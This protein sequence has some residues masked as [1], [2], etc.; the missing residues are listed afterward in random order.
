[1]VATDNHS[2][3][4]LD[5]ADQT[6][7][8]LYDF[9]PSPPTHTAISLPA[10]VVGVRL[11]RV[12]ST[13]ADTVWV[14]VIDSNTPPNHPQSAYYLHYNGSDWTTNGVQPGWLA[15]GQSLKVNR[16]STVQEAVNVGSSQVT[17]V[18]IF[19]A[20]DDG[21]YYATTNTPTAGSDWKSANDQSGLQGVAI[22]NV[23]CGR[24][25]F[26]LGVETSRIFAATDTSLYVSHNSGAQ[27]DEVTRG[28]VDVGAYLRD[29][30]LYG[31]GGTGTGALLSNKVQTI[32][33][34]ASSPIGLAAGTH[35]QVT[36][37]QG[38]PFLPSGWYWWRTL[39]QRY[40]W[41]YRLVNPA[42]P[43]AAILHAQ[44]SQFEA[45]ETQTVSTASA[46]LAADARVVL[47]QSSQPQMVL[48]LPSS[49]TQDN[50]GLRDLQPTMTAHVTYHGTIAQ[51][52]ADGTIRDTTYLDLDD[53]FYVL[54][55]K[56]GLTDGGAV[57]TETRLSNVLRTQVLSPDDVAVGLQEQVRSLKIHG[58]RRP[59]S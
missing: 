33:Q 58:I 7:V 50:A 18:R 28:T 47:G 15:V 37:Y 43:F 6:K 16:F 51:K 23:F 39:T 21:L 26:L 42:C 48:T 44:L 46:L 34:M 57:A 22:S 1:M 19:A 14:T 52:A 40:Q 20:T 27:W 54:G 59:R 29:A 35:V 11:D 32:G 55:H 17:P 4:Y 38:L 53:D 13:A 24:S 12:T 41:R 3:F 45:N 36:S 10:N 5:K 56:W 30:V 2:F 9:A 31:T 49:F 8:Y 25:Q